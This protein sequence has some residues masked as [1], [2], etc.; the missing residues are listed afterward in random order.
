MSKLFVTTGGAQHVLPQD[1][2][3][4]VEFTDDQIAAARVLAPMDN[5]NRARPHSVG[6]RASGDRRKRPASSATA[7]SA[8]ASPPSSITSPPPKTTSRPSWA[9]SLELSF[10]WLPWRTY[11]TGAGPVPHLATRIQLKGDQ[12]PPSSCPCTI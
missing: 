12:H 7:K 10:V 5:A 3:E 2:V 9:K 4:V 8:D 1:G 11:A 6:S